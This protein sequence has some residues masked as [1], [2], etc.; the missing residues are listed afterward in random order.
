MIYLLISI[1]IFNL[2]AYFS[3]KHLKRQEIYS[4]ALFSFLLG[5]IIDVIFALRYQLYGYFEQGSN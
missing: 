5:L 4:T 2:A 3:P 1:F